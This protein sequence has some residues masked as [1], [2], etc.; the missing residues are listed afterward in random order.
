[1]RTT[2]ITGFPGETD[3]Q[4]EEV[5]KFV[6]E[7]VLSGLGVFTYSLEPGDTCWSGWR[8]I[9]RRRSRRLGVTN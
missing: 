4:F 3:E 9:C 1:L 5:R 8:G 7:F 6:E 2:F